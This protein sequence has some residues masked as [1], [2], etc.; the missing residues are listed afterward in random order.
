MQS[1]V[2]EGL[3]KGRDAMAL[4]AVQSG[5]AKTTYAYQQTTTM[6]EE[7]Y[8]AISSAAQ[9][10]EDKNDSRVIGLAMI[11]Y[12]NMGVS[13]GMKAQYAPESTKDNPVIQV[14][15]NYGGEWV[16]YKVNVN[17]VEPHNASQLEM[18]ALLSYS[19]DQGLSDGGSFGSYHKMKVYAENAKINGYWEG[20]EDWESFVSAKYDW[21][22]LMTKMWEDY[23]EAGIY[24]QVLNCQKLVSTFD[25]FS[26]RHIDFDNL[27]MQDKSME[28]FSH[29][30]LGVPSNVMGA[31]FE[32]L[33]ERG[34]GGINNELLNHLSSKMRQ[35]FLKYQ[36]EGCADNSIEA[37][38]N[39]AREA[40]N[41]LDY[42]LT[43]E[44]KKNPEVQKELEEE[45]ALYLSF[46]HKL[47]EM[48]KE[49]D[50]VR[51]AS[52]SSNMSAEDFVKLIREKLKELYALIMSGNTEQT[53]QIG[54][55]S[56]TIKE[57]KE[58]LEAFDSM[59]DA[60]KELMKE[61]QEAAAEEEEEGLD[62]LVSESTKCKYH[63]TDSE[64]RE[65]M[66]ITWY[67]QE[68]IFCRRSGYYNAVQY[69]AAQGYEWS[70]SYKNSEDYAR[71]M[72]FLGNFGA[73]DN[74]LFAA[75][76]N[77]WQDF[78]NHKIHAGDFAEFYKQIMDRETSKD[79]ALDEDRKSGSE[80]YA[81]WVKYIS[82][83][84]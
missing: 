39:A 18:F 33:A 14:T 24:S 42:P 73:E 12:G 26:L 41:D 84:V 19:D 72:E 54:N 57:W 81:A 47:E 30:E 50:G 53:Y 9:M 21:T 82:P 29:Y 45:R 4:G 65:V 64:K 83:L 3:Q 66:Y 77:F 16:S 80:A 62:A 11:P 43:D 69:N 59:E 79:S 6:T 8:S 63:A 74:L 46:I 55:N 15:S 31:W 35:R 13:Y 68:G 71:V 75:H 2:T 32:A 38:L 76:E 27:K 20:N 25:H 23:S 44:I 40:L 67:T 22:A 1:R 70:I 51:E 10:T 61:E 56:F 7:F 49:N 78:L 58:F 17:E 37:A 28:T 36:S 5:Y 48:Q 52:E 34:E 60:I